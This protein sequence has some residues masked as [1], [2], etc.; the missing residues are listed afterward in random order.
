[1][2]PVVCADEDLTFRHEGRV[3]KRKEKHRKQTPDLI[4]VA[5]S[6]NFDEALH[7]PEQE[8]RFTMGRVVCTSADLKT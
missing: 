5:T 4:I 3:G 6:I 2:Q 1:M 8:E 7:K